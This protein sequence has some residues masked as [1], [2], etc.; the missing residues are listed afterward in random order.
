MVAPE[1]ARL[2]VSVALRAVQEPECGPASRRT[3]PPACGPRPEWKPPLEL[4]AFPGPSGVPPRFLPKASA[5]E[6]Q[7]EPTVFLSLEPPMGLTDSRSSG[8]LLPPLGVGRHQPGSAPLTPDPAQGWKASGWPGPVVPLS[9][10]VSPLGPRPES[11][12]GHGT[13]E[14]KSVP[15]AFL[16]RPQVIPAFRPVGSG[17]FPQGLPLPPTAGKAPAEPPVSRLPRRLSLRSWMSELPK[18]PGLSALRPRGGRRLLHRPAAWHSEAEATPPG[19]VRK[20]RLPSLPP[21]PSRR[22]PEGAFL[23]HEKTAGDQAGRES[24]RSRGSWPLLRNQA[25][26]DRLR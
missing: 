12:L 24:I 7:E 22:Q 14:S 2:P 26:A 25:Q 4:P 9:P 23:P 6:P 18:R 8:L 21:S 11:T 20:F 10:P 17:S 13:E 5:R 16:L 1:G 3:P 15:P 19:P